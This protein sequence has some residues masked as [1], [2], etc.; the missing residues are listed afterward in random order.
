[1]N[2][3]RDFF[4][5]HKKKILFIVILFSCCLLLATC[6]F[7]LRQFMGL[8]NPIIYNSSP[9]Y[10][11]RP[12]PNKEYTRFGGAKITFNNLGLRADRDWND[13][14]DDKMLFLG[15]SVTYGGSYIDN[16]ELFT[17]LAVQ[18]LNETQNL[19]YLDGNA[20]VNGWGVE[21]IYGLIRES[22]FL[23]SSIYVTVL[24]EGD[25]Y[26]GLTRMQGL[27]FFNKKPRFA[28]QELWYFFCYEQNVQRYEPWE[29]FLSEQDTIYVLEK[30]VKKLKEMD[31]FLK[32]KGYQHF[33]FI[34]PSKSQVVEE[35]SKNAPIY[36]LLVQHKLAPHYIIEKIAQYNLS[37]KEREGLFHDNVHLGKRGHE[38]WAKII[39]AELKRQIPPQ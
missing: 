9:I 33:L 5:K 14:K 1:M 10:G 13:E 22:A 36:N 37:K 12:L 21:N 30:A 38:L 26:R 2:K 39:A 4:E 19:H 16:K 27:P 29:T 7:L 35:A 23:P 6:E 25:F 17:H 3:N 20:G 32:E 28:L 11:Y 18:I 34:T 8:G 15:D 24:I 31:S